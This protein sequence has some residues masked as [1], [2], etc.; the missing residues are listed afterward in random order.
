MIAPIGADDCLRQGARE[1]GRRSRGTKRRYLGIAV[2]IL[3]A[4]IAD[5]E[6]AVAEQRIERRDIV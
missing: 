6:R 2:E 3:R 4:A 5:G 1:T